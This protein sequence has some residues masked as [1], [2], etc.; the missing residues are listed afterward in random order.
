MIAVT[1]TGTDLGDAP[2]QICSCVAQCW[3]LHFH[4]E[5]MQFGS[6]GLIIVDSSIAATGFL[7]FADVGLGAAVT[8]TAVYRSSSV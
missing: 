2:T 7:S 3:M 1:L 4:P 5:D 6:S 8:M